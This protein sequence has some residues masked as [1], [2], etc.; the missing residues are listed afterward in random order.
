MGFEVKFGFSPTGK[1]RRKSSNVTWSNKKIS[2]FYSMVLHLD[3]CH[4]PIGCYSIDDF[5]LNI[6]GD[7]MNYE[8]TLNYHFALNETKTD[9]ENPGNYENPE[10]HD[11]SNDEKDEGI[12]EN[13]K[14]NEQHVD[15]S[16]RY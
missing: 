7:L 10:N 4:E 13:P 1:V 11:D 15:K 12:M 14:T 2:N 5:F 3:I 6:L 16:A 9:N 8:R